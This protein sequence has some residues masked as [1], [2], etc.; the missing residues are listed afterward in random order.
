MVSNERFTT[1]NI[2]HL[3]FEK[4]IFMI[5]LLHVF[6]KCLI[7]K[8]IKVEIYHRFNR[9]YLFTLKELWK[10]F[11]RELLRELQHDSSPELDDSG[12]SL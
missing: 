12:E 2:S 8:L 6:C 4:I 5:I 11:L 3:I 10:H 9:V 1:L 7:Y